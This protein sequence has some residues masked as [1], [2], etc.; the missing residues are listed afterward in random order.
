MRLRKNWFAVL[1][2]VAF[3]LTA[4]VAALA[5]Q[6]TQTHLQAAAEGR[7]LG[8]GLDWAVVVMN[9]RDA[10]VSGDAL[11]TADQDEALRLVADTPGI[12]RV[13]DEVGLLPE[14]KPY[15]FEVTR[16]DGRLVVAGAAPGRHAATR[17][18][19]A[20]QQA[21][22]EGTAVESRLKL[23]RGAP[24][25]YEAVVRQVLTLAGSIAE[26]RV[27]A[28]DRTL[29]LEGRAQDDATYRALAAVPASPP[30]GYG[31]GH[32]SLQPPV[33]SPFIW[34]ARREGGVIVVNGHRPLTADMLA[35][36]AQPSAPR[37]AIE[38]RDQTLAA[39]QTP[40]NFAA[41][42]AFAFGLLLKLDPGSAEITDGRLAV[43]GTAMDPVTYA[44][45]MD[46]L[47]RRLPAGTAA[48]DVRLMP[49]IVSPYRWSAS[50]DGLQVVLNGYV[51]GTDERSAILQAAN[52]AYPGLTIS[53]RTL[54]ARG[55]PKE[56][57]GQARFAIGLLTALKSGEVTIEGGD[58]GVRGTAAS[59]DGYETL[60]ATLAGPLPS[61]L[62]GVGLVLETAVVSPYAFSAELAD[63]A[64]TMNGYV[65]SEAARAQA[66]E[67]VERLLP[68]RSLQDRR[69]VAGGAPAGFG[70]ARDVALLLLSRMANGRVVLD[71][72]K[73]SVAGAAASPADYRAAMQMLASGLPGGI[74]VADA[75]VSPAA[76]SPFVW[77]AERST[78]AIRLSGYIPGE[79]M[80]AATR[81]QLSRLVP[82]T[83]ITDDTL[84]A[85][86]APP[87]MAQQVDFALS[88]LPM[89]AEGVV[90]L[91][92]GTLSLLG[93]AG[94]AEM[95][96]EL[97]RMLSTL[98]AGLQRGTVEIRPAAAAAPPDADAQ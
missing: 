15:R 79:E 5:L 42:A 96:S 17:V 73:L 41:Q 74:A 81:A 8:G 52:E 88:L 56:F 80:R 64:V 38:L 61:G 85:A 43:D 50:R 40:P 13:R 95:G 78:D 20:A 11:S 53:D 89:L 57:E 76:A 55:A 6:P 69:R 10:T 34:K 9:G 25:G 97:Q 71:G 46:G 22:P 33:V 39:S 68:G 44:S 32:W 58:L 3:V 23:A 54:V 35:L 66:V 1:I 2:V 7:L 47:G 37:P 87:G 86:G 12:R 27:S 98:P 51:P 14:M 82:Q 48:A 30:E 45:I 60:K 77:Q 72:L 29:S 28:D 93:T 94:T 24:A 92:D 67:E 70:E 91:E 36:L 84:L 18:I 26:G 16:R 75:K 59:V 21:M 19:E 63:G 4:L 90:R 49:P 31:V 62:R 83:P 65:A